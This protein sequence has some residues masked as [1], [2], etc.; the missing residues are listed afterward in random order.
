MYVYIYTVPLTVIMRAAAQGI[1]SSGSSH[2]GYQARAQSHTAT[3]DNRLLQLPPDI[4]SRR[5]P[6]VF[7]PLW[8]T[9]P[10]SHE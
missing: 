8:R 7:D 3:Y 2:S 9:P 5:V 10:T 1:L 4:G 6:V